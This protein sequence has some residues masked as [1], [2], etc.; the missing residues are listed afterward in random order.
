MPTKALPL[1]S[2]GLTNDLDEGLPFWPDSQVD[3]YMYMIR[4]ASEL[5]KGIKLTGSP[6]Q[7]ALKNFLRNLPDN[8]NVMIVVK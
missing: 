4:P 8:Q 1:K 5:K 7:K 2:K 3:E 6:K